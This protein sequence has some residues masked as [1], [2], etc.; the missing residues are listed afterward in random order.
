MRLLEQIFIFMPRLIHTF[1]ICRVLKKRRRLLHQKRRVRIAVRCLYRLVID[2]QYYNL[3]RERA[4]KLI[5]LRNSI[6]SSMKMMK[7]TTRQH[8]ANGKSFHQTQSSA[9][10]PRAMER[11]KSYN[12]LWWRTKRRNKQSALASQNEQ[13][14]IDKKEAL[15]VSILSLCLS[16]SVHIEACCMSSLLLLFDIYPL[17]H[18][19]SPKCTRLYIHIHVHVHT[20]YMYTWELCTV[21]CSEQDLEFGGAT[22]SF[23][24]SMA[25][26]SRWSLCDV[27]GRTIGKSGFMLFELLEC[28][29]FVCNWT[30]NHN[31]RVTRRGVCT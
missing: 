6:C 2:F 8:P 3:Q 25:L 16:T 27:D 29:Y 17:S 10:K 23:R 30:E 21:H 4:T 18:S 15:S 5:Y 13:N 26:H 12:Q 28:T 22:Q 31:K 1:A 20:Y 11:P 14:F 24:S 9:E 19:Q 7:R